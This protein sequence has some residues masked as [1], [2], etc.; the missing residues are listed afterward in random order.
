[1][2][3]LELRENVFN[4]I[5]IIFLSI[6]IQNCIYFHDI[7]RNGKQNL[8]KSSDI[9]EH[10]SKLKFLNSKSNNKMDI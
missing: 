10:V 7:P 8:K 4:I 1:M 2:N 3:I 5:I 9:N 6:I